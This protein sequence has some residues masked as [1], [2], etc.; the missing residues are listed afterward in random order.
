MTH[1]A[2]VGL[3]VVGCAVLVPRAAPAQSVA[4][5]VPAG[6][7]FNVID[8]SASTSGAPSPTAVSYSQPALFARSQQLKVSVQ[9]AATDFSG[10]G[11]THIAASKVSWTAAAASGTAS[12]GTLS[13]TA[14]TQVYL[15][16]NNLKSGSTGTVNVTWTLAAVAAAGLRSGTHT[17]SV[18]WK[19]EAF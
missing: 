8:A 7:S 4:V 5:T 18:R 10:P 1:A 17:V 13:S 19:F 2:R 12:N 16:P 14:Y 15:S 6:V 9:A 3:L 11:S